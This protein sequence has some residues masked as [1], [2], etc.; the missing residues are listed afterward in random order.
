MLWNAVG[1]QWRGGADTV[2][3]HLFLVED[4]DIRMLGSWI[5]GILSAS[6]LSTISRQLTPEGPVRK[7]TAFAGEI[8]VLGMLL[9][10]ILRADSLT[11]S[12][13]LS[14]YHATVS[15]LTEDLGAQEK[16][17]L[18]SYI[19]QRTEAYILDEA[20]FLKIDDPEITVRTKWRDE[21]WVPYEVL[22][23]GT[24]SPEERAALQRFLETE[25]GIPPE[26][27]HWN[28]Q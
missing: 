24:A 13:A 18:R 10:P 27:Q 7:V 28:E 22:I 5:R 3:I 8:V 26:R 2:C 15:E 17:L 1:T 11:F 20:N 4:G 16:Q 19:E 23:K 14:E 12:Q 21:S 25:L 6:V 9:S